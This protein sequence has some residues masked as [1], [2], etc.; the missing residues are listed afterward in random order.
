[1][2]PEKKQDHFRIPLTIDVRNR[3][4]LS[5]VHKVFW[6]ICI[7]AIY[8]VISL[9]LLVLIPSK[10]AGLITITVIGFI[11]QYF[12]RL[13]LIRESKYRKA[14]TELEDTKYQM[15]YERVWGA[16]DI[17]ETKP[18]TVRFKNGATGYFILLEKG[19]KVGKP[20]DAEYEHH[21]SVADALKVLTRRKLQYYHIDYM[22]TTN[23]DGRMNNVRKQ[24]R[25]TTTNLSKYLHQKYTWLESV[26]EDEYSSYDVLLVFTPLHIGDEFQLYEGVREFSEYLLDSHYIYVSMLDSRRIEK[27]AQNILNSSEFNKL[28]AYEAVAT[29][30]NTT[31]FLKKIYTVDNQGN[32][33]VH[34]KTIEEAREETKATRADKQMQKENKRIKKQLQKE[35]KRKQKKG[36]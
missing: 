2:R 6:T 3:F 22:E 32:K 1:M 18:Y 14:I 27:L 17:D 5:G 10:V 28:D 7:L 21:E 25:G 24:Y 11:V 19:S 31:N 34:S 12:T 26:M 13:L 8:L 4:E 9:V 35:E 29:R 30:W 23:N 36:V 16:M 20:Q 15:G 33:E